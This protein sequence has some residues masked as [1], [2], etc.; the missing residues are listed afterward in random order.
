[1]NNSLRSRKPFN[2]PS[3]LETV[4]A[5]VSSGKIT[6][7][8]AAEELHEAGWTNYVDEEKTKRL[9]Q[10]KDYGEQKPAGDMQKGNIMKKDIEQKIRKA[11]KD[12]MTKDLFADGYTPGMAMEAA[13]HNMEA[14]EQNI[15]NDLLVVI[16]DEISD[17]F[18][19]LVAKDC[20]YLNDESLDARTPSLDSVISNAEAKKGE[21][22]TKDKTNNME[23]EI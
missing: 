6:I 5:D 3:I 19:D 8:E 12:Y 17:V 9:L 11:V 18:N 21:I 1:M 4:R 10:I 13:N 23:Y 22:E 15:I 16:K 2:V 7:R 14:I 20:S